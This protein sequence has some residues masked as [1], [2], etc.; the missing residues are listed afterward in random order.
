M[1]LKEK[2]ISI[3]VE[4]SE[5]KPTK[6]FRVQEVQLDQE[7]VSKRNVHGITWMNQLSPIR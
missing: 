3:K 1:L 6:N 5:V 2:T 4:Y 7:T